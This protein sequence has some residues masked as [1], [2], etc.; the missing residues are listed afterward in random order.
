MGGGGTFGLRQT[1]LD[2]N[3]GYRVRSGSLLF[4]RRRVG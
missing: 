3:G 4:I 2:D 1:R